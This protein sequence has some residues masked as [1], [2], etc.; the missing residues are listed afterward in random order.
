MWRNKLPAFSL[1]E[2]LVVLVLSS[3]ITGAVYYAYYTV[4]T[5]QVS[6]SRK[7]TS[8]RSAATLGYRLRTDVENARITTKL[9]SGFQCVLPSNR[10]ITYVLHDQYITRHQDALIDTFRFKTS[11][12]FFLFEGKENPM[13]PID[14]IILEGRILE[15]NLRYHVAKEYDAASLVQFVKRDSLP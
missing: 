10:V 11:E 7:Y 9:D 1:I 2:M 4:N 6:L 13:A 3:I 8:L 15:K 14:E 5:F 12:K